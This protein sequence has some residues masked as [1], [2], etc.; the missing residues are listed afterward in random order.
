MLSIDY[1]IIVIIMTHYNYHNVYLLEDFLRLEPRLPSY[2]EEANLSALKDCLEL[3]KLQFS[4]TFKGF[5]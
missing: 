3:K 1:N 4:V 5:F 2:P